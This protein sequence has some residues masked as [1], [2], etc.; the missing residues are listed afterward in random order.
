MNVVY[1]RSDVHATPEDVEMLHKD[2]K[3]EMISNMRVL[4][5]MPDIV[6]ARLHTHGPNRVCSGWFGGNRGHPRAPARHAHDA[7]AC[8]HGG[9]EWSGNGSRVRYDSYMCTAQFNG[10]AHCAV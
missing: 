8:V 5:S 1:S 4:D 6:W 3:E 9:Q 7:G 10:A 2:A